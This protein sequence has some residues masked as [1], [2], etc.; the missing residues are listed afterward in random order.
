[1][2]AALRGDIEFLAGVEHLRI[3]NVVVAREVADGSV[4]VVCDGEDGV[5]GLDG[6][7]GDCID[8]LAGGIGSG[9]HAANQK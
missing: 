9:S 8:V 2:G 3:G 7:G 4:V 1:M 5:V 6:V